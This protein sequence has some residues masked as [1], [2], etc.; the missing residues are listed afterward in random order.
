MFLRVFLTKSKTFLVLYP[1]LKLSRK[2]EYGLIS[3]MHMDQTPPGVPTS[4][5]EIAEFYS[6]PPELLGKVLQ[7]LSRRGIIQS[8]QG[9][10]GGY[11]LSTV[12]ESLSLGDVVDA[13]EGRIHIAPC[14]DGS[15]SCR[16]HSACNIKGPIQRIQ[17]DFVRY[18]HGVS[19]ARFRKEPVMV[20][21]GTLK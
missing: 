10:R 15:T 18:M 11:H 21:K 13:I 16:Q 20:M 17:E 14:C 3:L 6:I 8:V 2:V 4:S 7:A 12:L 1:M 5:K 9:S 19:L